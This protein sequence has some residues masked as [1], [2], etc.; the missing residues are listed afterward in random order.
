MAKSVCAGSVL[1]LWQAQLGGLF[2]DDETEEEKAFM[3]L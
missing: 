2:A 1:M 3:A